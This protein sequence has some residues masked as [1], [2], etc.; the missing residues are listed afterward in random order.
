MSKNGEGQ[1]NASPLK[2]LV[3]LYSALGGSIGKLG[4]VGSE[5]GCCV[6]SGQGGKPEVHLNTTAKEGAGGFKIGTCLGKRKR[7]G[8][9]SGRKQ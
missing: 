3:R 2:G 1:L 8:V 9:E 4:F 6:P 7:L 5:V